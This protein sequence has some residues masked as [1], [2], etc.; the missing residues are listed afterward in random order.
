MYCC[1]PTY[2]V[3]TSDTNSDLNTEANQYSNTPQ[4]EPSLLPK[5]KNKMACWQHV[6]R[7][8]KPLDWLILSY[9]AVTI[10]LAGYADIW[11]GVFFRLV[12]IVG[13][14]YGRYC[15]ATAE[16]HSNFTFR[17]ANRSFQVSI[18]FLVGFILD[19]YALITCIYIYGEDGKVIAT[20]YPNESKDFFD[21]EMKQVD[22]NIFRGV[23][24]ENG[25]GFYLRSL[26]SP[27]FNRILGEY[28]NFCYFFYY[29]ILVGTWLIA[30]VFI[31]REHFDL[32]STVQVMV[33]LVCLVCYLIVPVAGPYWT[34][35]DKR[36]D[37]EEV[38]FVFARLTHFLVEGGSSSGT[39]FPSGHCSMTTAAFVLSLI[40]IRPLG[41]VYIFTAP[42]L[43]FATVWGGFHYF[44][45]AFVGVLVGLLCCSLGFLI[46]R[47]VSY[48]LPAFDDKYSALFRA[49]SIGSPFERARYSVL[50][51]DDDVEM[52]L[53]EMNI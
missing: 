26:T 3:S 22:A 8:L 13:V 10:P 37:A 15:M 7:C 23:T 9:M 16:S 14:P 28:L 35:P 11:G 39:A 12:L 2:P 34:Y 30:W 47:T 40:Y 6:G 36:P 29:V 25:T 33:Y 52:N 49:Q 31:P 43:V 41:I 27:M 45:D 42:G 46:M 1:L 17:I 32:I 24:V 20:L 21:D 50:D 18:Q 44:I 4:V 48:N 51:D 5:N 53:T 38:G 19:S